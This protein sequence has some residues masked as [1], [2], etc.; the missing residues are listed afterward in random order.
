MNNVY[1][2]RP[3]PP[4]ISPQATRAQMNNNVA[5][6]VA[7]GDPRMNVKKYDRPGMSRGRAAWNQAGIDSAQNMSE[8]IADAYTQDLDNRQYQSQFD[9]QSQVSREQNAQALGA[10]NQQNAYANQLASLQRQQAGMNFFSSLL[11]GLLS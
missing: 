10:L 11:G 2:N 6:A 1:L 3:A 5:N 8:R 9:L 7:T 4:G